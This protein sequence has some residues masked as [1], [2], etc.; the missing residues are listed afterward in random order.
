MLNFMEI[1]LVIYQNQNKQMQKL[2]RVAFF[3]FFQN[4]HIA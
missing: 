2:V 3:F 1:R 4:K